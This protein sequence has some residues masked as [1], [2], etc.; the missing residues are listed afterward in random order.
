[1]KK[2]ALRVCIFKTDRLSADDP[3]AYL[4]RVKSVT[5]RVY[6]KNGVFSE[7]CFSGN[8]GGGTLEENCYQLLGYYLPGEPVYLYAE[9]ES[10]GET[11]YITNQT[12]NGT[13][14]EYHEKV[15]YTGWYLESDSGRTRVSS[16]GAAVIF[17]TGEGAFTLC[18]E[19]FVLHAGERS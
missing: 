17:P 16:G 11:Y 12:E 3:D 4:V 14:R 9:V 2:Y 18:V 5:V 19:L 6:D 13:E 1:M 10:A 8:A 7:H 15:V